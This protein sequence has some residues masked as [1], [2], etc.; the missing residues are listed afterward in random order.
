VQERSDDGVMHE[1]EARVAAGEQLVDGDPEQFAE[2]LAQLE[3]PVRS[4]VVAQVGA[5]RI[6]VL[7]DSRKREQ[8]VGEVELRG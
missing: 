5:R 1:R 6:A 7:A 3:E 8:L 4:P 2:D